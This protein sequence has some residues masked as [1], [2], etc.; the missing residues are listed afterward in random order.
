MS[1]IPNF[2]NLKY[3]ELQKLAKD[4]GIKANMKSEK[5]IKALEEYFQ[6]DGSNL[7]D[8][9][10]LGK[11]DETGVDSCEDNLETSNDENDPVECE[12]E[13]ET[14]PAK[15]KAVKQPKRRGKKGGKAQKSDLPENKSVHVER[16]KRKLSESELEDKP[17]EGDKS[18]GNV[19]PSK[20]RRGTFEVVPSPMTNADVKKRDS[21]EDVMQAM[22][23]EM[24]SLDMKESLLAAIEK[25]V[26]KKMIEEGQDEPTST[27]SQIPRFAAFL[28]KKKAEKTAVTPGNKNWTKIHEKNFSKMDSID[29]YLA[30]KRKRT[31]SITNSIKQAKE[32]ASRAREAMA[33]LSNH[34]TPDV[35]K[36]KKTA[37]AM[38]FKSPVGKKVTP[39]KPSIM[40]TKSLSFNFGGSAKTPVF[41]NTAKRVS[42]VDNQKPRVVRRSPR[43]TENNVM[44]TKKVGDVSALEK[45]NT[46]CSRK[47]LGELNNTFQPQRRKSCVTP[48]RPLNSTLE[49]QSTKKVFDL[50]ASLSKPLSWKPY[51]GKL[52]PLEPKT[53][54]HVHASLKNSSIKVAPQKD[55]R[56]KRLAEVKG[57]QADKKFN[58][59]MKR[60][61]IVN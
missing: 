14:K 21:V 17:D 51:T 24:N 12:P 30:K 11:P 60:R 32:A 10:V 56:A 55:S 38:R 42:Q 26:E 23:P 43:N 13:P 61:G 2:S 16:G 29:V 59:Q 40:S 34:K 25:K 4:V 35:F 48:Y 37:I 8:T 28:A 3:A 19:Q 52:K 46:L 18:S 57:R 50:Q 20:K 47:S 44:S 36:G 7:K 58:A 53:S 5:L 31:Q 22:K 27:T 15:Q 9:D 39:F 1:E 54:S 6:K 45:T 41:G 33:K 49:S